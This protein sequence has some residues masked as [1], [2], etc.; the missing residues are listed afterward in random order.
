VPLANVRSMG[1]S[2]EP[3]Q[4]G[5]VDLEITGMTCSGCA[6]KVEK[7]LVALGG[8][9]ASVNAMT[10]SAAVRFDPQTSSVAQ[11]IET[12]ES[13]GYQAR[14]VNHG[15]GG[16]AQHGGHDHPD[17]A[18]GAEHDHAE[19]GMASGDGLGL[20]LVLSAA[21]T[22]PTLLISMIPA[23]QFNGWA[24][25]AGALATPVAT[26]GAWPFHRAAF[27]AAKHRMVGMDALVS[28]G[29]T[30][31]W[32]WSVGALLFG[33]AGHAGMEM[34]FSLTADPS[35]GTSSVYFEVAAAVT[36]LILLGRFLEARAKRE[37]GGAV[38]ALLELAAPEARLLAA[39]AASGSS[40]LPNL[41]LASDLLFCQA[42]GSQQTA[43]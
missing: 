17:G 19:H 18:A 15:H 39:T 33:G 11:L 13:V 6:A 34:G 14:A 36:T 21:L 3:I 23:L 20:R 27:L 29:V 35:A 30:A 38:R 41:K 32:G 22:L 12:V 24:W 26:W 25:V 5:S 42:S 40:Q 8:V 16:S 31:A 43:P 9:E 1:T 2:A 4:R 10:D 37:A 28:L 7:A